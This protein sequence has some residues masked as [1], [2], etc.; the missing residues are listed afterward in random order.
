LIANMLR[1]GTC[2]LEPFRQLRARLARCCHTLRAH[3][4]GR[5]DRPD[6]CELS[7]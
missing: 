4:P 6:P 2:R 1:K 7:L 3:Q 5:R